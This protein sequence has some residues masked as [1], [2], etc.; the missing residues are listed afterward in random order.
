MHQPKCFIA[1]LTS[2]MGVFEL[3]TNWRVLFVPL[4]K[5]EK[6]FAECRVRFLSFMGIA[7]N[8]IRF[9]R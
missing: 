1:S 2:Q 4:Q 8:N 5:S 3:D 9:V 6:Q 7:A